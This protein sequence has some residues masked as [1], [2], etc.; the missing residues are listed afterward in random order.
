MGLFSG[1]AGKNPLDKDFNAYE[2]ASGVLLSVVASDG[3]ISGEEIDAF[4]FVANRHPIFVNQ[5]AQDFRRMIDEQFSILRKHG[6][7]VLANKA[8]S[9]V[10]P[11]M[12]GT[13]FALAVDFVL[14]DGQ[15]DVAEERLIGSL[16]DKL[17]IAE[18]EAYNIVK[19][20]A[21]KNGM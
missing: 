20:L 15:I 16:R 3:E 19:V 4:V 13:V 18:D 10:P 11:N 1:F 8:A 5:S 6:W 21:L 9:F 14:A 7:D 2:A 17:G 12:R